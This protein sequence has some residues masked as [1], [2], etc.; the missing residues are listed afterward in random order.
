MSSYVVS[1]GD[2]RRFGAG[3]WAPTAWRGRFGEMSIFVDD[4]FC[5]N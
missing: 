1:F 3:D 2:L 5:E 4:R